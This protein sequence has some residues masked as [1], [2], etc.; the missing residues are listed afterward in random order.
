MFHK[1]PLGNLFNDFG[2]PF[3]TLSGTLDALDAAKAAK[4]TDQK[5]T[6]KYNSKT[7]EKGAVWE[8][9]NLQIQDPFLLLFKSGCQ[10]RP[11]LGP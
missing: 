6:R 8:P 7:Y 3:G 5:N 1:V 10:P 11:G 9:A 4:T 2:L